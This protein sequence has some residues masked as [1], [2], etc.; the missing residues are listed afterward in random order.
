M[1]E[2]AFTGFA[3]LP[4]P[5]DDWRNVLGYDVETVEQAKTD[6]QKGCADADGVSELHAAVFSPPFLCFFLDLLQVEVPLPR[7]LLVGFIGPPIIERGWVRVALAP[8]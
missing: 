3:A 2:R 7:P 8:A 4:P 5:G 6:H 1:M